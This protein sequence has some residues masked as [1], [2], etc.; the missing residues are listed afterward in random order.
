MLGTSLISVGA[1]AAQTQS[2]R[3]GPTAGLVFLFLFVAA[4]L[5]L[6]SMNRH[7]KVARANLSTRPADTGVPQDAED[8]ADGNGITPTP[9]P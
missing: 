8:G 5:L 7:L 1:M 3:P 2:V 4:G 9:S 6:R